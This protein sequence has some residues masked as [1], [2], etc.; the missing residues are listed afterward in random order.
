V[1]TPNTEKNHDCSM[2]TFVQH[3]RNTLNPLWS[4]STPTLFR[5]RI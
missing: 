5:A 1:K 4:Q 2:C 3:T